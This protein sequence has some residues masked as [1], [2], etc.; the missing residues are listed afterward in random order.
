MQ[1]VL[2]SLLPLTQ[3]HKDMST[4]L[5]HLSQ[6]VEARRLIFMPQDNVFSFGL[7][8]AR[9][10]QLLSLEMSGTISPVCTEVG[11]NTT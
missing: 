5:Q 1:Y 10:V 8:L 3:H 9:G 7:F 6:L 4:D 11:E 2:P